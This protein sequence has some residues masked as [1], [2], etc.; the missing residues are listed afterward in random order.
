MKTFRRI[1]RRYRLRQVLSCWLALSV[2]YMNVPFAF[3]DSNPA[4]GAL[5][6]GGDYADVTYGVN[7]L[8]I[9][10]VAD[11]TIINWTNFDI[12]SSATV[13]FD[14]AASSSV[15]NRVNS[16]NPT[17]IMGTL[18][19]GNV[20]IVNPAG[21]IF[22]G[23]A[24][25]N[26]NQLIASSH[27]LSD[28]DFLAGND[29]FVAGGTF[30][31]VTVNPGSTINAA[32]GVALLGHKVRNDGSITTGDNGYVVMASGNRVLLGHP[33]SKV[34]VEMDS[35]APGS[36]VINNG[37]ITSP[38][39][40]IVLA[41]GDI[42][43]TA[44][45]VSDKAVKVDSGSGDVLQNGLVST[46]NLASGANGGAI[47]IGGGDSV[48]LASGSITNAN[49]A[50]DG[51]GGDVV[52]SSPGNMAI[53]NGAIVTANGGT[54]GKIA[55]YTPTVE[56]SADS[57]GVEDSGPAAP[58]ALTAFNIDTIES[59]LA[60]GDV[61]LVTVGL[62]GGDVVFNATRYVTSGPAGNSLYVRSDNDVIFN[63][64][65]GIDFTGNSGVN[66]ESG[67]NGGIFF[68]NNSVTLPGGPDRIS[69]EA[70][71]IVL[72]G[73]R[74]GMVLGDLSIR[75]KLVPGKILLVTV[76]DAGA[77]TGYDITTGQMQVI[78]GN[79]AG[80]TVSSAG[81]LT[82]NGYKSEDFN[83][84]IRVISN[85]YAEINE[86]AHS[87]ICLLAAKDLTINSSRLKAIQVEAH[88]YTNSLAEIMMG[89]GE[90]TVGGYAG[91]IKMDGG[92]YADA[93]GNKGANKS[94]SEATIRM[95]A[96]T[97]D[98][99]SLKSPW[100]VSDGGYY[101]LNITGYVDDPLNVYDPANGDP[102]DSTLVSG[103][104]GR[105]DLDTT[106]DSH[107]LDC[108]STNGNI[109]TD[110]PA[111]P[112]PMLELPDVEG[113]PALL[114][115]AAAEF[116]IT[117]ESLQIAIGDT[118]A[119]TPTIQ[120]CEACANVVNYASNLR[121]EQGE[122][123]AAINGIFQKYAD[124]PFDDTLQA[125][126]SMELNSNINNPDM[127]QYAAA[128][129]YVESFV[130]YIAMLDELNAPVENPVEYVMGK[131]GVNLNEAGN[132]TI[133]IY[134]QARMLEL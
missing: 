43:S 68:V 77:P 116:G 65:N 89:A 67:A 69:T 103:S 131:Y 64:G 28:A 82:V 87:Y 49:G 92:S 121:D 63:A 11:G 119:T 34:V 75:H 17:G 129:E 4:A 3:A 16:A 8:D 51:N 44:L 38:S 112:L 52:I 30:G 90:H 5:P 58:P 73:G 54:N 99:V 101:R 71:D 41:A 120:A 59:L 102:I 9:N 50:V 55:I 86:S 76:N 25:V 126:I 61:Y 113:C 27:N 105:V 31:D 66:I 97:L 40:Q 133:L 72:T 57:G 56:I 53:E 118:Q 39:G 37:T 33:G 2:F 115:A 32:E 21:V 117:S 104:L 74:G 60:S 29:N 91:T 35:A 95:Y 122:Y 125:E 107:C 93:T 22:G 62:P 19:G 79:I 132:E 127:P 134:I 80:I 114:D 46:E 96:A 18:T 106:K 10:N 109:V 24:I 70:G 48:R 6:Q 128:A 130:Q 123:L 83:G 47:S 23:G 36:S 100:A 42:F 84:A 26:V 45:N 88:G 108:G 1:C 14:M 13:A 111:A 94:I 110:L 15:L 98:L 81:S 12:G 85:G 78:G 7:K 124:R 20:Y